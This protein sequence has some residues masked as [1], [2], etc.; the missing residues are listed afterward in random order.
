MNK[1]SLANEWILI[2]SRMALITTSIKETTVRLSNNDA[3]RIILTARIL[4][5]RRIVRNYTS[6]SNFKI[7]F[8][9]PYVKNWNF[10]AMIQNPRFNKQINLSSRLNPLLL[11]SLNILLLNILIMYNTSNINKVYTVNKKSSSSTF[12]HYTIW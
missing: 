9:L 3:R 5:T 1:W 4:Y 8:L 11:L 12:C 6:R 10:P 2:N 7:A